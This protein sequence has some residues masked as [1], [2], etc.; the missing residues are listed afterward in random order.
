MHQYSVQN[1]NF[2]IE[3]EA[4]SSYAYD[5]KRTRLGFDE[6]IH[7][8]ILVDWQFGILA[9]L[10]SQRLRTLLALEHAKV[11]LCGVLFGRVIKRN[12]VCST[13]CSNLCIRTNQ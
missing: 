4:K 5:E 12:R 3:I 11:S 9:R 1:K 13:I 2:K 7:V 6:M 8:L 10:N